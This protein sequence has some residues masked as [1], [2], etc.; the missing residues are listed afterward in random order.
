M[1][2]SELPGGLG[3]SLDALIKNHKATSP[4]GGGAAKPKT[5]GGAASKKKTTTDQQQQQQKKKPSAGNAGKA[6]SQKK[7]TQLKKG[8]ASSS[9][10]DQIQTQK[11]SAGK[12]A[13]K[14]SG[15][16]DHHLAPKDAGVGKG[17]KGQ[18]DVKVNVQVGQKGKAGAGKN[19]TAAA[20]TGKQ[21][22]PGSTVQ[23]SNLDPVAVSNQDVLELFEQI[24]PLKKS[25]LILDN[26]G[27]SLGM[28]EVSF[29]RPEDAE[30]AVRS[31]NGVRLDGRPM[32]VVLSRTTT[33]SSGI[34][35]QPV[36]GGAPPQRAPHT[37]GRGFGAPRVA[38]TV[39]TVGG[40]GSGGFGGGRGGGGRGAGGRGGGGRGGSGGNGK[41]AADLDRELTAFMKS[42]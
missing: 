37:G 5:G 19:T 30:K 12:G 26:L 40:R 9:K 3:M 11:Q 29:K 10:K 34:Q 7:Q 2:P 31:Y 15:K 6:S 28:A 27:R 23:V 35:V 16:F 39:Q 42:D 38:V 18:V 24:G 22:T 14:S 17:R 33:L 8:G 32:N 4:K 41:S 21:Q 25:G 36:G 1:S 20:T 13:S